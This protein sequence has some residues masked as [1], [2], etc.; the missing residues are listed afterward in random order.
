MIFRL[1][2][3]LVFIFPYAIS[4]AQ[5]ITQAEA[6]LE[7]KSKSKVSGKITFAEVKEGLKVDYKI[8]GLKKDQQHGF[9]IH[10]KGDCSAPNA[11][12]AGQHYIEIAPK[13]GTSL[14]SP[15][16]YAGDFPQLKADNQ[17]VATGSFVVPLLSVNKTNPIENRAIVVHGGPDDPKQKSPPRIACGVIKRMQ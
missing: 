9:H 7:S 1:S 13:D 12:S 3:F 6:T 11:K 2:F 15:K 16:R 5:D 17:G 8:S 4:T 14:D 10:E